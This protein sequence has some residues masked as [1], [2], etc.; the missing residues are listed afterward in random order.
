VSEA[1][2][3]RA[4]GP[5][6]RAAGPLAWLSGVSSELPKGLLGGTTTPVAVSGSS[7]AGIVWLANKREDPFAGPQLPAGY[8]QPDKHKLNDSTLK[9]YMY[10]VSSVGSSRVYLEAD[11]RSGALY[12]AASPESTFTILTVL[13]GATVELRRTTLMRF[14]V[15]TIKP[16][17]SMYTGP[18]VTLGCDDMVLL[19]LWCSKLRVIASSQAP[20]D[21]P[22]QQLS[23]AVPQGSTMGGSVM[24]SPPPRDV[25][26][27]SH[28]LSNA[29]Y[30]LVMSGT[31]ALGWHVPLYR[32]RLAGLPPTVPTGSAAA[33]APPLHMVPQPPHQPWTEQ[34]VAAAGIVTSGYDVVTTPDRVLAGIDVRRL[35]HA[36]AVARAS[37]ERSQA[38][39]SSVGPGGVKGGALPTLA[40]VAR[41]EAPAAERRNPSTIIPPCFAASHDIRAYSTQGFVLL[42]AA[43]NFLTPALRLSH[44]GVQQRMQAGCIY[45]FLLLDRT[46]SLPLH[47]SAGSSGDSGG[48][49]ASPAAPSW[50]A[51]AQARAETA[52]EHNSTARDFYRIV[53]WGDESVLFSHA[54]LECVLSLL[55]CGAS[56]AELLGALQ[57]WQ[58]CNGEAD[59]SDVGEVGQVASLAPQEPQPV[60]EQSCVGLLGAVRFLR[61]WSLVLLVEHQL[62]GTVGAHSVYRV[63]KTSLLSLGWTEPQSTKS[64]WS[65][66][67]GL[68]GAVWR[69]IARDAIADADDRYLGH[70]TSALGALSDG[71]V[72]YTYDLTRPLQEQVGWSLPKEGVATGGGEPQR[73]VLPRFNGGWVHGDAGGGEGGGASADPP[74]GSYAPPVG[75][76]QFVHEAVREMG[77]TGPSASGAA[78]GAKHAVGYDWAWHLA[79]PVREALCMHTLG[80]A[81]PSKEALQGMPLCSWLLPVML[82]SFKQVSVDCV[83]SSLQLTVIGRRSSNYAGTRYLKRGLGVLGAAANDVET[84]QIVD[85]TMGGLSSW[86]QVRSSVPDWWVQ[87]GAVNIAR[88]PINV[89][90]YDAGA[91]LASKA[92]FTDMVQRFGSPVCCLNLL[93]KAERAP[94]ELFL[95]ASFASTVAQLNATLPPALRIQYL[96]LDFSAISKAAKAVNS[97][98]SAANTRRTASAFGRRRDARAQRPSA[99]AAAAASG[100]GAST[101]ADGDEQQGT[102]GD[103]PA[104]TCMAHTHVMTALTDS[105]AWAGMNTGMFVSRL[106]ADVG[107]V[108][109]RASQPPPST[110]HTTTG[111]MAGSRAIHEDNSAQHSARRAAAQEWGLLHAR[112]LEQFQPGESHAAEAQDWDGF[113]K[114]AR[115]LPGALAT[116]GLTLG[117]SS[118]GQLVGQRRRRR[119]VP[120]QAAADS[121]D[122]GAGG[123]C[124]LRVDEATG[125]L[126]LQTQVAL[127]A[128][129]ACTSRSLVL[130]DSQLLTRL[131][132]SQAAAGHAGQASVVMCT[133]TRKFVWS[134][135][136]QPNSAG[137]LPP[138]IACGG[139]AVRLQEAASVGTAA[140]TELRSQLDMECLYAYGLLQTSRMGAA[141]DVSA[142]LPGENGSELQQPQPHFRR[143]APPALLTNIQEQDADSIFSD[144]ASTVTS[145]GERT[146]DLGGRGHREVS[147]HHPWASWQSGALS[148]ANRSSS[149][150]SA[151]SDAFRQPSST[152]GPLSPSASY[153]MSS[154]RWQHAGGGWGGSVTPLLTPPAE[155]PKQHVRPDLL[156]PVTPLHLQARMA[157]SEDEVSRRDRVRQRRRPSAV[158]FAPPRHTGAVTGGKAKQ[159][160]SEFMYVDLTPQNRI[161]HL[162]QARHRVLRALDVEHLQEHLEGGDDSDSPDQAPSQKAPPD[163]PLSGADNCNTGYPRSYHP[164]AMFQN[165][166]LRVNCMDCLDR[167]NVAMEAAGLHMLGLQLKALGVVAHLP[168]TH[169]HSDTRLPSSGS[170]ASA[171]D[172]AAAFWCTP[173]LDLQA[174]L[175]RYLMELYEALGDEVAMQYAGSEANKRL[176]ALNMPIQ[177][178]FMATV[179]GGAMPPGAQ[180]VRAHAVEALSNSQAV[181][182]HASPYRDTG[183]GSTG[184]DMPPSTVSLWLARGSDTGE[185]PSARSHARHSG[186]VKW[187]PTTLWNSGADWGITS[188]ALPLLRP[189]AP[190][191]PSD[192][193]PSPLQ[194]RAMEQVSAPR[195]HALLG[196]TAAAMVLRSAGATALLTSVQRHIS[197]QTSD[198]TRQTDMNVLLGRVQAPL[199]RTVPEHN[200]QVMPP[201]VL[202]R[203][204]LARAGLLPRAMHFWE[205]DSPEHGAHNPMSW[206]LRALQAVLP[207]PA[208]DYSAQLTYVDHQWVQQQGRGLGLDGSAPPAPGIRTPERRTSTAALTNAAAALPQRVSESIVP[209]QAVP[210]QAA[211][212]AS[213]LELTPW[214]R[215]QW[216]L[217]LRRAAHERGAWWQKL[218][219]E[220]LSTDISSDCYAGRVPAGGAAR[221]KNGSFDSLS[222]PEATAPSGAM[223]D[224]V[225]A[226]WRAL[227][228]GGVVAYI[229]LYCPGRV[230][231]LPD[232]LCTPHWSRLPGVQPHRSYLQEQLPPR[233]DGAKSVHDA[234]HWMDVSEGVVLKPSVLKAV[235]RRSFARLSMAPLPPPDTEPPKSIVPAMAQTPALLS[236]LQSLQVQVASA[237]AAAGGGVSG[238]GGAKSSSPPSPRHGGGF[239]TSIA[240]EATAGQ[241]HQVVDVVD[242]GG[243]GG[244]FASDL[245]SQA[246][247]ENTLLGGAG[248]L[249]GGV[250]DSVQS[251]VLELGAGEDSFALATAAGRGE[252]SL[253]QPSAASR[254]WITHSNYTKLAQDA[255]TW[256]GT[257]GRLYLSLPKVVHRC[258]ARRLLRLRAW[259]ASDKGVWGGVRAPSAALEAAAATRG[260]TS[261]QALRI[262]RR[263]CRY[264][265]CAYAR[266]SGDTVDAI[267]ASLPP[268]LLGTKHRLLRGHHASATR[269][270]NA[271]FLSRSGAAM[272]QLGFWL[273]VSPGGSTPLDRDVATMPRTLLERA[274]EGSSGSSAGISAVC[275]LLGIPRVGVS[276]FDVT[277]LDRLWWAQLQR[278][279]ASLPCVPAAWDSLTLEVPLLL[280]ACVVTLPRLYAQSD[281]G[282]Q[283]A[284]VS[285]L[286]STR[287]LGGVASWVSDLS[288]GL[289]AVQLP[290]AGVAPDAEDDIDS[291]DGIDVD[292]GDDLAVLPECAASA[293]PSTAAAAAS[294]SSLSA[295]DTE[296]STID[297]SSAI[298][299]RAGITA[300][301][302]SSAQPPLSPMT[303]R[304]ANSL[305]A[306]GMLRAPAAAA[307]Q[308]HALRHSLRSLR[309][310]NTH[311]P[312]V[313]RMG[314]WGP[315]RAPALSTGPTTRRRRGEAEAGG[316]TPAGSTDTLTWPEQDAMPIGLL[317]AWSDAMLDGQQRDA[318]SGM[319]LAGKATPLGGGSASLGSHLLPQAYSAPAMVSMR[320][321][322]STSMS[323]DALD[324]DGQGGVRVSASL[325]AGLRCEGDGIGGGSAQ[326]VRVPV[327]QH[328]LPA[329]LP[330]SSSDVGVYQRYL[331][332]G[333][334]G[335]AAA[336]DVLPLLSCSDASKAAYFSST[337]HVGA[338]CVSAG[339]VSGNAGLVAQCRL[340]CAPGVPAVSF[341]DALGTM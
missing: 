10:R 20:W 184:A 301:G 338:G 60:S 341:A 168:R 266:P 259:V 167:T 274:H 7:E 95:Q 33:G 131:S 99:V 258:I 110:E 19:S 22:Q 125:E 230:V 72:S 331:A 119:F 262:T 132:S 213:W 300:Q 340:A 295:Q 221:P 137:L 40:A 157:R 113:A 15:L 291:L 49:S 164:L 234:S 160:A 155:G 315:W 199:L 205:L 267:A 96:S 335:H 74:Q 6:A 79:R 39:Q 116:L 309:A 161:V 325:V 214:Q 78:C 225:T 299:I 233:N 90:G 244:D 170:A 192:S 314:P 56:S 182:T 57:T 108:L 159:E 29:A 277:A 23:V 264:V 250:Y 252:A 176:S 128:S 316:R 179:Q 37:L 202:V 271:D 11:S 232:F 61:H 28:A 82:G 203:A 191:R 263:A 333:G 280:Q 32:K 286:P 76:G 3:A 297:G 156:A 245:R 118:A 146:L 173:S 107:H 323:R 86:R 88:P 206:L 310:P 293:T 47:A 235:P 45:R 41:G 89:T 322:K 24:T 284:V 21:Q 153:A 111:A 222:A 276:T 172:D 54:Q 139:L 339:D 282:W 243:W 81:R 73:V 183:G 287:R 13:P 229:N 180:G 261:R 142:S 65:K 275:E 174:P 185:R 298:Q 242:D 71:H 223:W 197:N 80:S 109:L 158:A 42:A 321:L 92:H 12:E 100:G 123:S 228:R 212:H 246:A 247:F 75:P 208:G 77:H 334:G 14:S 327:Y 226:V 130:S 254:L 210:L 251:D 145:A 134:S 278:P 122:D 337:V 44:P 288:D 281:D 114:V 165:G 175:A 51:R 279:T 204:A 319:V 84:E 257:P 138:R 117:Q 151:G 190:G 149:N 265:D 16:S 201:A 294:A 306:R 121:A 102:M 290:T 112:L 224:D 17:P 93:K 196:N 187:Q 144:S 240:S 48:S 283:H 126:T 211:L 318:D 68:P 106:A 329:A 308:P 129:A 150:I 1:P 227:A 178:P 260:L 50:S 127:R 289:D 200:T 237:A 62:V 35:A 249:E 87:R 63:G 115:S 186:P 189:V 270:R 305:A 30:K 2:T 31:D 152:F 198:F 307:G 268:W 166:V 236:P 43:A 302:R 207:Y 292:D 272:P 220:S 313:A 5:P 216:W 285:A 312:R 330:V 67:K 136:A 135:N 163:N 18:P 177:F 162:P 4:R 52:E 219:L 133:P 209:A 195:T 141:G 239:D 8:F 97:A 69:S 148:P 171:I 140:G 193:A 269:S 9:G 83:G 336:V 332:L 120:S 46:M 36:S 215:D 66:F 320:A 104:L 241:E 217:L 255:L 304:A 103:S 169:A 303:A 154:G 59:G 101:G 326:H 296:P 124:V 194:I 38:G 58:D 91:R 311:G 181:H 317:A 27:L 188:I 53:L 34:R 253:L 256:R 147:R 328:L 25:R 248:G 231:H 26:R 324:A 94:R 64:T 238:G 55:Q 85:D 105:A 273:Q 143:D 98:I 70:V 218:Q